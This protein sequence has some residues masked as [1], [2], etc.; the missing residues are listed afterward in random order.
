MIQ[1]STFWNNRVLVNT[2]NWWPTSPQQQTNKK[3]P[4][5]EAV[6][7]RPKLLLGRREFPGTQYTQHWKG[8]KNRSNS[9]LFSL[10]GA[11]F[12]LELV[13]KRYI[14]SFLL[15][16]YDRRTLLII[17]QFLNGVLMA[18]TNDHKTA[19]VT[20]N[21]SDVLIHKK[22]WA[23]SFFFQKLRKSWL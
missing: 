1:G 4:G 3:S 14:V 16:F 23:T 21:L 2:H 12:N 20:K 19:N 18:R 15:R 10:S 13:V 5:N 11:V 6:Q 17:T 22:N 9:T 7:I 8:E